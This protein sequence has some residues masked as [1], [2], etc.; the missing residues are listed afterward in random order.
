MFISFAVL[1]SYLDGAST[2]VPF[3]PD[4]LA[5][6]S[7]IYPNGFA[8]SR[9]SLLDFKRQILISGLGRK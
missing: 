5:Q 1:G 6:E 9:T 3:W 2:P 7:Q 8:D 4:H